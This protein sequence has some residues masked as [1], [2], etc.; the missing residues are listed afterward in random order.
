[1]LARCGAACSEIARRNLGT[2]CLAGHLRPDRLGKVGRW[3]RFWTVPILLLGG[4][5]ECQRR[6]VGLFLAGAAAAGRV[7]ITEST[8][9]ETE[10]RRHGPVAFRWNG[11]ATQT[12]R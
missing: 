8:D 11:N 6:R 4:D 2:A 9:T 10:R 1:M 5:E 3:F 7:E 12:Q